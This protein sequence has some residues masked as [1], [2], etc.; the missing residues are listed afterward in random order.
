MFRIARQGASF[1]NPPRPIHYSTNLHF[2][3]HYTVLFNPY[4]LFLSMED[5]FVDNF[6]PPRANVFTA[7][8][9]DGDIPEGLVSARRQ[10]FSSRPS[11]RVTSRKPSPLGARERESTWS[12]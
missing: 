6:S 7:E 8:P 2:P 11:T 12:G 3:R 9:E 1:L 10:K 5:P 4:P